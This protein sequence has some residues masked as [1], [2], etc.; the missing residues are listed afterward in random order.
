MGVKCMVC[1]EGVGAQAEDGGDVII[2]CGTCGRYKVTALGISALEGLTT[3]ERVLLS[4][5]LRHADDS[6]TYGEGGSVPHLGAPGETDSR[7][8]APMHFAASRSPPRTPAD[9]L[10]ALLTAVQKQARRFGTAVQVGENLRAWIARAWA[11]DKGELGA[12]LEAADK[13]G[14][15]MRWTPS[16]VGGRVQLTMRG[17][18]RV[19]SL[20][21]RQ[22]GTQAFV[23]MWFDRSLDGAKQYGF[24]PALEATGYRLLRIDEKPTL[25]AITDEIIAGIRASRLVVADATGHRP[26]VYY[27][28]G[29]AHGLGAPVIWT[30]KQGSHTAEMEG[31]TDAQDWSKKLPFDTSTLSH[32]MW[33]D[34]D[35]L[36]TKLTNRIEALGLSL[37]P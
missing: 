14:Y 18:Q 28:A 35:D 31:A 5:A 36:R 15:L 13:E 9:Q 6:R 12:L 32:I 20:A 27:E 10:D 37:K 8:T 23:A 34:P 7:G 1:I 33:T 24:E 2:G 19:A 4:A 11:Q 3:D 17:S 16:D 25:G 21:Q 26:S 30:C 22:S 29:F